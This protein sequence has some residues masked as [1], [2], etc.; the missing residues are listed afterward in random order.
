[1]ASC[2]AVGKLCDS[3]QAWVWVQLSIQHGVGADVTVAH[4]SHG[5]RR[6][7]LGKS[8]PETEFFIDSSSQLCDRVP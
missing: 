2:M 8:F 4:R 1:M 3:G 6:N 5:A 7:A